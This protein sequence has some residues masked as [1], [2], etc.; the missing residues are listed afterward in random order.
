MST[1]LLHLRCTSEYLPEDKSALAAAKAGCV[2]GR[3][4]QA[5]VIIPD[6]HLSRLHVRIVGELNNGRLVPV[7][8]DLNSMNGTYIASQKTE[9]NKRKLPSYHKYTL[10]DDEYICIGKTNIFVGIKQTDETPTCSVSDISVIDIVID[11]ID[12]DEA[13]TPIDVHADAFYYF[14]WRGVRYGPLSYEHMEK[15]KLSEW[16]G[17]FDERLLDGLP[18]APPAPAK[19]RTPKP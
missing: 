17:A 18:V 12:N 9:G 15:L 13:S 11:S 7:V 4:K 10:S 19:T 6:P 3:G 5:D 14:C 16:S 2:I 1:A 8:I